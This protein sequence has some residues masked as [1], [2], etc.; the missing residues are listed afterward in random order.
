V[1]STPELEFFMP[2]TLSTAE[3][4]DF[5]EKLCDVA[6]RIFAERGQEGFTMRELAG[7]LG[8]SPMTPYRY[9]HDK[10][11]ILAAVR[12]RIFLQFA[13]TL[14]QAYGAPGDAGERGQAAGEAYVR[15]ALENPASY[16][17][18]FDMSQPEDEK[19]PELAQAAARAR[20]TMTRHIPAMIEAGMLQG[21]PEV[22]G[23]VFWVILHGVVTLQLA[24]K[25]GPECD[26]RKILDAA[27]GAVT[28]GLHPSTKC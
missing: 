22:I 13:V 21:D 4:A 12:A 7:E 24:G 18:M 15:F 17:L 19:Y 2:R 26:M 3:V 27:F 5:R 25:L 10:D 6:A 20:K 23:H 28:K 11:E 1:A 9:F 16:K 8:V 14:E